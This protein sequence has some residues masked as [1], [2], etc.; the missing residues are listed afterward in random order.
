MKINS[1]LGPIDTKDLGVTLMHEH[2]W[3][4]D[5]SFMNA[6]PDWIDK[7]ATLN[8]F[9][10]EI[11]QA[12][13]YGLKTF[14]DAT[15]INLGRDIHMLR[16]A[17]ERAEIPILCSTGLY[18]YEEPW[19]M[20]GKFE[21]DYLAELMLREISHGIQGTDSKP[22]LI[23]CASDS[24]YKE[25]DTNRGMLR[26]AAMASKES[27]VPITTH[28]DMYSNTQGLY[29]LDVLTGEG[30][31]PHK[32]IIGHAFGPL[33]LEYLEAILKRGAYLGCDRAGGEPTADLVRTLC[34]KGYGKQIML[35]RD[36]CTASDC[37]FA[38]TRSRR[39]RA[40][41]VCAMTGA[42]IPVFREFIPLLLERGLTQKQVDEMLIDNPRRYFEGKPIK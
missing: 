32:I 34:R 25:S 40:E 20:F 35:S 30:V 4:V 5:I 27:G 31:A 14:V 9:K 1:V 22:A 17:S 24:M 36:A 18:H 38:F 6:F 33:D 42:Y 16:A 39:N 3:N 19:I 26:A 15:P 21:P 2:F 7:E 8:E 41:N 11:V 29:Q 37:V 13:S 12:K 23:K 10:K 28:T